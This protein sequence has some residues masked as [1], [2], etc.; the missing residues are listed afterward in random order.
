MK[1]SVYLV[2]CGRLLKKDDPDFEAYANVYDKK[3]GYYDCGDGQYYSDKPL[4]EL[5]AIANK[6]VSGDEGTYAI[7]SSTF[8]PDYVVEDAKEKGESVDEIPVEYEDYSV[9]GI[10]Y[11]IANIDGKIVEN[12]IG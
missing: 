7:I 9:N 6:W 11:S 5:K 8:L 10:V 4:D 1:S 12:F 2:D 3:Y